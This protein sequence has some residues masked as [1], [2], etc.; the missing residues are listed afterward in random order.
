MRIHINQH[1]PL[2]ANSK[3]KNEYMVMKIS[4]SR[5]AWNGKHMIMVIDDGKGNHVLNVRYKGEGYGATVPIADA[6]QAALAA[7]KFF[8]AVKA[9]HDSFEVQA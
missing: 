9:G 2:R 6:D 8:E 1:L 4:I 7:C 3:G 5:L